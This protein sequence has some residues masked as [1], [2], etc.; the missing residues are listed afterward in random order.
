[1]GVSWI[2]TSM[3]E[4]AYGRESY[5]RVLIEIDASEGMVDSIDVGY[6][7]QEYQGGNRNVNY[8]RDYNTRGSVG[9]TVRMAH[10]NGN[11]ASGSKHASSQYVLVDSKENGKSDGFESVNKKSKVKTKGVF[12]KKNGVQ[13][14]V[15]TKSRFSIFFKDNADVDMVGDQVTKE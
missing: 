2:T 9:D 13:D 15:H 11:Q 14:E 5:A 10:R 7:N 12:Q 3:C 6:V 4:K 1:M 8:G